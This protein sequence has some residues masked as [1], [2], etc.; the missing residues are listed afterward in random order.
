MPVLPFLPK[1]LA[2]ALGQAQLTVPVTLIKVT[3][4]DRRTASPLDG[5]QPEATSYSCKGFMTKRTAL[6]M[7]GSSTTEGD[8]AVAIL[9]AS[10]PDGV[11][12]LPND[13]IT[14]EGATHVVV[15]PV[16]RDPAAAIY[17]CAVRGQ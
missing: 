17:T 9:G 14:V 10:L 5:T 2:K 4:G 16:E 8:R 12:P 11:E 13:R 15:G 3:A 6:Q 1:L 7:A